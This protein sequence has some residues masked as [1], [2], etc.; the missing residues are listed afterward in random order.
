MQTITIATQ[1]EIAAGVLA[2][3]FSSPLPDLLQES[4]ADL[5]FP[6][7]HYS[8]AAPIA[9]FSPADD[10]QPAVIKI[11]IDETVT[12]VCALQGSP[13][14]N[15]EEEQMEVEI[16]FER[17]ASLPRA[18]FIVSSFQALLWL[19]GPIHLRIPALQL[20]TQLNFT[21]PLSQISQAL[22]RRQ[23]AHR[24]MVIERAIDQ[25]LAYPTYLTDTDFNRI[26]FVYQAIVDRFFVWPFTPNQFPFRADES[27][28]ALLNEADCPSA[29]RLNVARYESEVLGKHLIL[30]QAI[31]TVENAVIGNVE[32]VRREVERPDGHEFQVLI[33]SLSGTASY[34]FPDAPRLPEVKWDKLIEELL[35]LEA[36]LDESLFQAVNQLVAGSLPDLTDEELPPPFDE[37]VILL[38]A[39]EGRV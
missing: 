39:T 17:A 1:P 21:A 8:C 24:L 29:C 3:R 9:G 7:F 33:K 28:G 26:F 5:Y 16:Q 27:A 36:Q 23:I 32:E 30:G 25:K 13:V 6:S 11:A 38:P 10:S 31:V 15:G 34:E 12:M 2:G 37:D 18:A 4:R 19:A 22:R 35:A 14:S 20:D